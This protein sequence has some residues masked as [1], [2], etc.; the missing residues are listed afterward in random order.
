MKYDRYAVINGTTGNCKLSKGERTEI[1]KALVNAANQAGASH[2]ISFKM[3]AN[4]VGYAH[5]KVDD[6]RAIAR[7]FLNVMCDWKA[8]VFKSNEN[9]SLFC[10][11]TFVDWDESA[12]LDDMFPDEE[13]DLSG[14]LYS[15]KK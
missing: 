7:R 4:S 13:A 10:S 2:G 5:I 6:V 9:D 3:V 12:I 15:L 1:V 14:M 11:L 8:V